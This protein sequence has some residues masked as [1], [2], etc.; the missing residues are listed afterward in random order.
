M[1]AKKFL[2]FFSIGTFAL[3]NALAQQESYTFYYPL[4]IGDYWEYE[5]YTSPA[6]IIIQPRRVVGDTLMPNGKNYRMIEESWPG[7]LTYQRIEDS[8]RVYQ[9]YQRY[10]PPEGM[11]YGEF[12]LYNLDLK[13]G[14]T[15]PYPPGGYDGFIAD[16]G[17]VEVTA[18]GDT[19]LWG[20]TFKYAWLASY[21]LP[22]TACWFCGYDV[23]LIDSI[24]VAFDAVEMAHYTLLGAVINGQKYG[25]ITSVQPRERANFDSIAEILNAYP[26]P[27]NDRVTV[28][29]HL[30]KPGRLRFTIFNLLGQKVRTLLDDYQSPGVYRINWNGIDDRGRAV[31]SDLYLYILELNDIGVKSGKILFVK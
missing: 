11:I 9:F 17:F 29:Y 19:T 7:G 21:T 28:E 24:G 31:A 5:F 6:F 27:F 13:L 26:N 23:I 2:T 16:S 25:T 22:D 30:R 20:H 12:L 3:N 18:I 10:E 1:D 15:W 14:D 4:N 8:T